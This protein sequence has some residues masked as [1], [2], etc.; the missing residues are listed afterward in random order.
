MSRIFLDGFESG[1]TNVWDSVSGGCVIAAIAGMSGAYCLYVT[2]GELIKNISGTATLYGAMRIQLNSSAYGGYFCNTYNVSQ[3]MINF[4]VNPTTHRIDVYRST[5]LIASGTIPVF[6]DI[7]YRFEFYI[8]IDDSAGRVITKIDGITDV[9]FTG[10]TKPSTQTTIDSFKLKVVN[11]YTS[12]YFDDIVLDNADWIGDTRIQPLTVNGAG[13]TTQWT[14]SA[15]DNYTC[16]DEVP[17]NITD[18]VETNVVNQIDTYAMGNL[19]GDIY[20]I[21]CVQVQARVLKEGSATPQNMEIVLRSGGTNYFSGDN[22]VPDTSYK[23]YSYLWETDPATAVAW[24]EAG[25][26]AMEAGVKSIT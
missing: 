2:A 21:K 11:S 22:A 1:G 26:N 5:T 25:V 10:D 24:I 13:T 14:P 7:L 9:D 12:Q 8:Y 15:G 20:S 18:W 19:V 4:K 17:A 23:T 6:Q 16:I 3:L